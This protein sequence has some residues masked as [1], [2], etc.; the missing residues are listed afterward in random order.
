[1]EFMSTGEDIFA[2][3]KTSRFIIADDFAKEYLNAQDVEV[4]L[5]VLTDIKFWGQ[6]HV[7]D[8]LVQWCID[9]NCR[10]Q[11]ATVEIDCAQSLTAFMLR[12]T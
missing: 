3:W 12:W 6:E 11:G 7:A 10:T 2:D 1:M 5:I 4:T 8:Q 9:H